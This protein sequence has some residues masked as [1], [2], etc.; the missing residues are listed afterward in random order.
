[1]TIP[2]SEFPELVKDT[3]VADNKSKKQHP[4]KTYGSISRKDERL[5]NEDGKYLLFI[6]EKHVHI[7][8][9]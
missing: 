7:D 8:I 1:M 9:R 2:L 6:K 5:S 4:D 3:S